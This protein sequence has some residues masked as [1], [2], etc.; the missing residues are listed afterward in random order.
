MTAYS[1]TFVAFA[2]N[3]VLNAVS[4]SMALLLKLVHDHSLLLRDY[5]RANIPSQPQ[6]LQ[7]VPH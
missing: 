1:S 3:A 6:K 7:S 2:L 5:V 4:V